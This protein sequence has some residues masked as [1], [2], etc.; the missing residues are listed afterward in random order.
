MNT[1]TTRP[2]PD[3]FS[4]AA[5]LI[6][7]LEALETHCRWLCDTYPDVIHL[8]SLRNYL[9]SIDTLEAAGRFSNDVTENRKTAMSQHPSGKNR[10]LTSP[11]DSP[12]IHPPASATQPPEA[13]EGLGADRCK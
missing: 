4:K 9:A 2:L 6:G 10:D 3:T 11:L 7:A 8:D 5:S 1:E 12:N 13:T